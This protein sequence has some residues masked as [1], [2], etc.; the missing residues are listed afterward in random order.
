M[1]LNE[2][3]AKAGYLWF[4]QGIW[5]FRRNPLA[6]LMLFFTY[7]F[8]MMVLSYIPV[9]GVL[10]RVILA[11]AVSVGFMIAC[12]DTIAGKP[13]LPTTLVAGLHAYGFGIARQ[14]LT[15]GL[16]YIVAIALLLGLSTLCDGGLLFNL[17]VFNGSVSESALANSDESLTLMVMAAAYIP[18][19]MLFWFAPILT[20]WHE[21]PPHKA[22]FFSFIA[23]WRNRTAFALYC[24][25]WGAVIFGASTIL[26][27]VLMAIG[28][29]PSAM[30]TVMVP[31]SLIVITALYCSFY[32]TYR[33][34]FTLPDAT[35][36]GTGKPP[37]LID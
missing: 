22:L 20:A 18:I 16:M 27:T 32:A 13:V 10:L 3:G 7:I 37:T 23:C 2:V 30:T 19:L 1:Q 11:P 31:F 28:L 25:I 8:L 17:L 4:R 15:L 5:L 24:L 26:L 6:L 33:G 35:L 14:L 12:R 21:V 9:I 34:C 29:G 36:T